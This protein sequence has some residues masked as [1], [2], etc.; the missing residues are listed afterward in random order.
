[1][2]VTNEN[3]V[4]IMTNEMKM[5]NE[6]V[7]IMTKWQTKKYIYT[8]ER[9]HIGENKISMQREGK[10]TDHKRDSN[11]QKERDDEEYK[12][13]ANKGHKIRWDKQGKPITRKKDKSKE[14]DK[15]LMM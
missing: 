13:R 11:T 5:A 2:K 14:A 12:R 3:Y 9:E 6:D 15:K 10:N 7:K 4:K 8:S 1:M